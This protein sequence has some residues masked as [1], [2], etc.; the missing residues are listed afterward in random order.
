MSP[1]L[2]VYAFLIVVVIGFI[3][4]YSDNQYDAGYNAHKAEIADAKDASEETD[5]A[6]VKTIIKWREKEKVVFRDKIKFI[7]SVKDAT[8]C[9]DVKFT[10]M[11]FGL[12]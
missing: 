1:K 3:K 11:G 9:A 7:R 4:W 12:Q 10:D 5:K 2:Y 8:G 6:A